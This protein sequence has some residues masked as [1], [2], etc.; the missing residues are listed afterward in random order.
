MIK[1]KV[2][3]KVE[4]EIKDAKQEKLVKIK[5][6]AKDLE[7]G[8]EYMAWVYGQPFKVLKEEGNKVVFCNDAMQKL[9]TVD[10]K[11]IEKI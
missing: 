7:T 8:S 2:V 6:G 1:K 11:F 10:K 5:K 4:K 9:G 3:K